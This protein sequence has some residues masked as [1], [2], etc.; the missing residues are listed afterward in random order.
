M[1]YRKGSKGKKTNKLDR[2][3]VEG[4]VLIGITEVMKSTPTKALDILLS[5][6]PIDMYVK[7]EELV[8]A[9]RLKTLSVIR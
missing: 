7:Q 8:T 5:V 3:H 4:M 9:T 2:K 6:L 1:G